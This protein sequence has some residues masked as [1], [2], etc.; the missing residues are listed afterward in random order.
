MTDFRALCEELVDLLDCFGST[1]NIPIET[2]VVARARAALAEQPV[3]PMTDHI[4]NDLSHL[5]DSE[6]HSLCPQG[7]H[8]PGS[9]PLSPA[10]QAV[11]DAAFVPWETTDTPESIAAAALR[12][13]ADQVVPKKPTLS[14]P[15]DYELGVWVA[16]DDARVGL[17]AI[18][19]E[20]EGHEALI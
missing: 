3:G 10:A 2:S 8:A 18:A 6:F 5:S 19:A 11:L 4:P 20:L 13:A 7:E 17:L 12:A 9:A 1:F 15:E 14:Y 16:S